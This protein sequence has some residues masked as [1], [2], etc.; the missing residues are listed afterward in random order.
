MLVLGLE[1]DLV[2][3]QG[4]AADR[5]RGV[6]GHRGRG[7]SGA[8]G[9]RARGGRDRGAGRGGDERAQRDVSA[10]PTFTA[11]TLTRCIPAD[12]GNVWLNPWAVD[13]PGNGVVSP[14]TLRSARTVT[15]AA[16]STAMR[17]ELA[18]WVCGSAA[19]PVTVIEVAR[20]PG[21]RSR[22]R[23]RLGWSRRRRCG[24]R[25][26]CPRPCCRVRVWSR[27]AR[28]RTP[29]G[30]RRRARRW[31]RSRGCRRTCRS[32]GPRRCGPLLLR[33]C[34]GMTVR[35]DRHR[36]RRRGVRVDG[37]AGDTHPGRAGVQRVE[38]S[39]WDSAGDG[40]GRR[41]GQCGCGQ[42][43]GGEAGREQGGAGI[44]ARHG[45]SFAIRRQVGRPSVN[46]PCAA[47]SSSR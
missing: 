15:A 32:R 37:P 11:T 40:P 14:L 46:P 25:A 19:Q 31:E 5:L 44:R 41:G 47:T 34:Q 4:R 45:G 24:S 7:R 28:W 27:C 42:G 3:G 43:A 18:E 2:A 6:P 12:T 20:P 36:Y 26:S 21:C 8:G 30:T 38:R 16:E 17:T 22:S 39:E 29:G 9:D 33:P 13:M 1:R 23:D 35:R 10:K